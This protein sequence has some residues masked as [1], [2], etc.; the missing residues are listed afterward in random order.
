MTNPKIQKN[1][2]LKYLVEKTQSGPEKILTIFFKTW[3][4]P[5]FHDR[6]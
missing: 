2:D 6:N 1:K 4:S 5:D 3:I